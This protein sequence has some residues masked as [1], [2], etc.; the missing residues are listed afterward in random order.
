[1]ERFIR[2]FLL[3]LI[4]PVVVRFSLYFDLGLL[5]WSFVFMMPGYFIV[6]V[7]F[8]RDFIQSENGIQEFFWQAAFF[9][10]VISIAIIY[11]FVWSTTE[12]RLKLSE[13]E[14]EREEG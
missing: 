6:I 1:M 2:A 5:R 12:T 8:L 10:V 3:S 11:K 7:I 13:R 9:Q 14:P 4:I